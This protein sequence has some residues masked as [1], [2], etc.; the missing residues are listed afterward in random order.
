[1]EIRVSEE[2]RLGWT[3]RSPRSNSSLLELVAP[4]DDH[5]EIPRSGPR[6]VPGAWVGT[7][8][9]TS[10]NPFLHGGAQRAET[11]HCQAGT[12]GGAHRERAG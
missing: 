2:P 5:G 1:M 7:D 4:P 3:V 6:L 12:P 8:G 10:P 9:R 11:R